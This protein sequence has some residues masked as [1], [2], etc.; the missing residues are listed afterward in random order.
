[1]HSLFEIIRV[2]KYGKYERMRLARLVACT[3]GGGMHTI[4]WPENL[5]EEK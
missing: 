5:K 1:M 4:L 2:I 3:M